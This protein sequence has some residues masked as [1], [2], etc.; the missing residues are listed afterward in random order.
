MKNTLT[1]NLK[2]FFFDKEFYL[3]DD[4][5]FKIGDSVL[6]YN[7][8]DTKTNGWSQAIPCEISDEEIE[9]IPTTS[10]SDGSGVI[11]YFAGKKTVT[12][13]FTSKMWVK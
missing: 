5:N 6:V 12:R 3:E 10:Y 9:K 8:H 2:G 11:H 13:L 7:Y 1:V 4:Q